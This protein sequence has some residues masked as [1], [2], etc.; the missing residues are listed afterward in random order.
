MNA[1][2]SLLLAISVTFTVAASAQ[3]F[4]QNQNRL[5]EI[6]TAGG[7]IMSIDRE[8]LIGDFYMRQIRATAPLISDPALDEYI[9]DMGNRMVRHADGVRFPFS[10]FWIN[11]NDINAFAFLGGHV[12]VHT[13]L[14]LEAQNESELAAVIGHEIAH[15]T[16]RHMVR[17]I[18]QQSQN[19]GLTLASVLGALL[20][21]I[22]NP[23][24]G[25]A[26]LTATMA[27][28]QQSVINYTR[29]YEQEADRVGMTILSNAGFDPRG[30]PNF[31][32]RLADRYR[33]STKMPEMLMT[34][35]VTE[36]RIADTRARAQMLPHP[37]SPPSL[38]FAL[39]KA[40]V[41]ARYGG[42]DADTFRRR[43]DVS[44]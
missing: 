16:Q 28:N 21:G 44:R 26:A 13:G 27:G 12:G 41:Q 15:V 37:N 32:G 33:Y 4:Q 42:V 17:N 3:N 18:E 40:R 10:F 9:A 31:F 38:K 29:L 1:V 5:P 36:S 43:L 11:N 14:I 22:A 39:A 6:G 19:S 24:L 35:P 30:A 20:L 2:K 34:H 23:E 25:S 8:R 7:A